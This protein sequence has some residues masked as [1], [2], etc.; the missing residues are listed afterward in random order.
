MGSDHLGNLDYLRDEG[1][2]I[3]YLSRTEGV[4]ST[5]LKLEKS[6]GKDLVKDNHG[7]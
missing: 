3:E 1:I 7:I 4:S 5:H 6:K 2:N